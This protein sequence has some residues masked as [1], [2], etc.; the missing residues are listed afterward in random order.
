M[1]KANRK[2]IEQFNLQENIEKCI[3]FLLLIE[4]EVMKLTKDGE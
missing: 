3:T 1:I 2:F 4:K